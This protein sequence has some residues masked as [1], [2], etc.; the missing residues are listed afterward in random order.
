MSGTDI[1]FR[2]FSIKSREFS[3][4]TARTVCG[5]RFR[6]TGRPLAARFRSTL[7]QYNLAAISSRDSATLIIRRRGRRRPGDAAAVTLRCGAL[8]CVSQPVDTPPRHTLPSARTTSAARK[9]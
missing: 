4:S 8:R 5:S 7:Y 9:N 2:R 1:A 3:R 6:E